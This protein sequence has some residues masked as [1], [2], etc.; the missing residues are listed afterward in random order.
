MKPSIHRL[1]LLLAMGL[2]VGFV[3]LVVEAQSGRR[4]PK[5]PD[6]LPEASPEPTATVKPNVEKPRVGISVGM[7]G[8]N[9]FSNIP[10]YF[11]DSVL[12]SCAERLRDAPSVSVHV[13]GREM[14]RADAV[15]MAKSQKEGFVVFLELRTDSFGGAAQNTNYQD[16]YL[17]YTVFGPDTAKVVTSG[18]TYQ[19]GYRKGGIPLPKGRNPSVYAE[20]MLQEA[21]REAAERILSALHLNLPGSSRLPGP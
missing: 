11:Y 7:N 6:P 1:A 19:R 8:S 20:Q 12:V 2:C 15:R 13:T 16:V 9:G 18:H 21:A 10:N 5:K 17:D 14:N 3:T 4:T